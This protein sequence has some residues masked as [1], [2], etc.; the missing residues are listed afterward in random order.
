MAKITLQDPQSGYSSVQTFTENNT[1]IEEAL[2]DKVLYRDNPAGED[3]AMQNDL[4]MNS[5]RILNLP[6]ASTNT[7]PVT[8][9]QWTGGIQTVEFTGYLNE[10][11][12]AT[13][14][15]TVFTLSNAYTVGIGAL[16]VFVNGV[17]QAPSAYSEDS[18]TQITFS[19]GL[20]SGDEVAFI[21]SSFDAASSLAST[22][23]THTTTGT[24]ATGRNVQARLSDYLSVK[25]FGAE[26]DASI[27]SSGVLSGTDD[28][29]AVQAALDAASAR[30]IWTVYVPGSCRLDS[31]I[32]IPNSVSLVGDG[33]FGCPVYRVGTGY[34]RTTEGPVLY[35]NHGSGG[36]D[37]ADAAVIL[38][39][40]SA[41]KGLSFWYPGQD[42]N[43]TTPTQF[44]P[45]ITVSATDQGMAIEDV[46]L[47][48]AYIGVEALLTHSQLRIQN[49]TGF[50]IAYGLRIGS[51]GDNPNVSLVHFHPFYAF[52]GTTAAANL[53]TW[54]GANGI[55]LDLRRSSWG[56]FRDIFAYG[57]NYGIY[58]TYA[59]SGTNI[60]AGGVESGHFMNCSFDSCYYPMWFEHGSG[61][62]NVHWGC[63]FENCF[64]VANDVNDATR[65]A[66][67][68]FTW[69]ADRT[70]GAALSSFVWRDGKIHGCE[71]HGMQ[72]TNAYNFLIDGYWQEF[73]TGGSGNGIELINCDYAWIQANM[74]GQA[75]AG[76]RGVKLTND[77]SN[78][79]ISGVYRDFASTVI[80]IANSSN[81]AYT[82][83]AGIK[84]ETTGT[85][86]LDSNGNAQYGTL[87]SGDTGGTGSAGAGNQYVELTID[88]T[89]YKVLHDGTV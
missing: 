83:D 29:T 27:N 37:A 81:T 71:S 59:A 80:E 82:I 79:H 30:G 23:V 12:T 43:G 41:I 49:V 32:N 64:L 70:A 66:P 85:D 42:M 55:A 88:G 2:N 86:I 46:N 6:N 44:P 22:S 17:Y 62:G 89:T 78:I 61:T 1:A 58:A 7:E 76:I 48:N 57:Y 11:Q 50:P 31:Q 54:I 24:G 5:N 3:N 26:C 40:R 75:Q 8:Y 33:S 68:A 65:T 36:T 74:D 21:I 13:A 34:E 53:P 10:T 72:I 56:V 39:A 18:T 84:I 45:A 67:V 20:D 4:D 35:V 16:R 25:D 69:D 63:H 51:S 77:N 15:Q 73:G 9:G 87:S 60:T 14:G 38:N 47:G 28:S 19:E 52:R